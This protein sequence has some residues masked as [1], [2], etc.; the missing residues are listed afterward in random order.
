MHVFDLILK[1][2]LSFGLPLG[3]ACMPK[4][5]FQ[6]FIH[7]LH[8]IKY[9]AT[10]RIS[11]AIIWWLIVKMSGSLSAHI[12]FLFSRKK[13]FSFEV[14]NYWRKNP[15]INWNWI[16]KSFPYFPDRI[17]LFVENID[18]IC[19]SVRILTDDIVPFS[20]IKLK[21]LSFIL[22]NKKLD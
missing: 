3:F 1:F 17:F 5:A 4:Y 9:D 16:K 20:L 18:L 21:Y 6:P 13:T 11:D 12:L 15:I 14:M 2:S 10:L 7:F 22:Q 8:R 19:N